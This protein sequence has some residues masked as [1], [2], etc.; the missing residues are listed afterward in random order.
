MKDGEEV[1][2]NLELLES[3]EDVGWKI[4]SRSQSSAKQARKGDA[5]THPV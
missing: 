3:R 1:D 4:E 2:V 5:G